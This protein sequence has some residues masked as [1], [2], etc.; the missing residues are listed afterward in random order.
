LSQIV[1]GT[2]G[3]MGSGKDTVIEYIANKCKMTTLGISDIVGNIAEKKGIESTRENLISV[4]LKFRLEFG[5]DYFPR[6]AVKI[7]TSGDWKIVGIS[8]L[9]SQIDVDVFRAA[10]HE[11]FKLI[12]IKVKNPKTRFERML[13][14]ANAKDRITY[15]QFLIQ[16]RIERTEFKIDEAMKQADFEINNDGSLTALYR[17]VDFL[18]PELFS[19]LSS[20]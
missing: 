14:R 7:I 19:R 15:E 18:I 11:E 20:H 12:A 5:S 13:G 2:I 10:F 3:L 1:V 8:G 9:R 6:E 16:D 4:S 17:T